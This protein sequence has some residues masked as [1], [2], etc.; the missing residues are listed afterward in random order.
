MTKLN[1]ALD[2]KVV[3]HINGLPEV[4]AAIRDLDAALTVAKK[5]LSALSVE[6]EVE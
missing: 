2:V 5:A 6:L 3:A 1:D 4:Q